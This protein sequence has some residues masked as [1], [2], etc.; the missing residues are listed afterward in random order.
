MEL[1]IRTPACSQ[2]ARP[3]EFPSRVQMVAVRKDRLERVLVKRE[4]E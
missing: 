3:S 2:R 1:E 4:K